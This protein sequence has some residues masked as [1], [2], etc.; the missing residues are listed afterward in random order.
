MRDENDQQQQQQQHS[1]G[2][3]FF[4]FFYFRYSATFRSFPGRTTTNNNE[5]KKK[6]FECFLSIPFSFISIYIFSQT[7]REKRDKQE[8]ERL[9]VHLNGQI[10]HSR[11]WD[12]RIFILSEVFVCWQKNSPKSNQTENMCVTRLYVNTPF[13]CIYIYIS[14]PP[15]KGSI[16]GGLRVGPP[17][18]IVEDGTKW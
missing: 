5:K 13:I 7:Q 11:L 17:P 8:S 3:S 10:A 16:D 14:I 2:K 4:L 1:R 18:W 12:F 6:M 15:K 9:R